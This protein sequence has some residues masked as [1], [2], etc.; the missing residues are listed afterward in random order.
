MIVIRYIVNLL[1]AVDQFCNTLLL[2][3]P[4]ET[5]SS[6]LGRSIGAERYCWVKPFRQLVDILFF[7]DYSTDEYG[8]RI[9]HCQKSVMP[10]EIQNF[11][12]ITDYEIWSWTKLDDYTYPSEERK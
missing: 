2:G 1:L 11:R 10:L 3:H 4:D 9:G 7:F 8:R 5:I 6:R 12:T